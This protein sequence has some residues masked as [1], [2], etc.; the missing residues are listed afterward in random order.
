MLK[1]ISPYFTFI[2][3]LYDSA[4]NQTGVQLTKISKF[5]EVG[6]SVAVQF[7]CLKIRWRTTDV[8]NQSW[9]LSR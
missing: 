2:L 6:N 3:F 1:S 8:L 7:I 9:I 5:V 4:L